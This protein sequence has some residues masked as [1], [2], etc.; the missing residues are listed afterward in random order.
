MIDLSKLDPS[1]MT[2]EEAAALYLSD[3]A[4]TD[5]NIAAMMDDPSL[6]L[7]ET[8][9]LKLDAKQ[10]AELRRMMGF[11]FTIKETA[12]KIH[13]YSK[14]G[15]KLSTCCRLNNG[16][17]DESVIDDLVDACMR[18]KIKW[19]KAVDKLEDK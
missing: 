11:N 17:V 19:D 5:V 8:N 13:V 1:R 4:T 14:E 18:L 15:P 10:R 16:L 3:G 2:S 7:I 12:K 6:S 9:P